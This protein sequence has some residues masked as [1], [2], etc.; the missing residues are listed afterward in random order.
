[1][2]THQVAICRRNDIHRPSPSE[3]GTAQTFVRLG[4][5]NV[6]TDVST[7]KSDLACTRGKLAFVES[8]LERKEAIIDLR[9]P[10]IGKQAIDER[11]FAG[12]QAVFINDQIGIGSFGII[13]FDDD[14][15]KILLAHFAGAVGRISGAGEA[16]GLVAG[17]I[18]RHLGAAIEAEARDFVGDR[19]GFLAVG[20]SAGVTSKNRGGDDEHVF[21]RDDVGSHLHDMGHGIGFAIADA[22]F[23]VGFESWNLI[24]TLGKF[25]GMPIVL[26]DWGGPNEVELSATGAKIH[27]NGSSF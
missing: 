26:A 24:L 7:S 14:V 3:I 22:V 20:G 15:E 1:M 23:C 19:A 4:D 13:V 5:S 18:E 11:F 8:R 17:H 9:N 6:V 2:D 10:A 16:H 21:R 27:S 25:V 12:D